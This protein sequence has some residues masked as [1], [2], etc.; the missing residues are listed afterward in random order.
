MFGEKYRWKTFEF[1]VFVN[2]LNDAH[3]LGTS[4]SYS[5]RILIPAVT[6]IVIL[7]ILFLPMIP[8][9]EA[10][11]AVESY[12]REAL[13]ETDNEYLQSKDLFNTYYEYRVWVYN[14]D[15]F[16]GGTFNVTFYLYVGNEL[17]RA[18]SVSHELNHAISF[19]NGLVQPTYSVFQT[20]FD[21]V[22]STQYVTG[23]FIVSPPHGM[24]ERTVSKTRIIYRSVISFFQ[25]P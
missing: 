22:P 15:T 8:T 14:N 21:T 4:H 23:S 6:I 10:Y 1:D 16:V 20:F 18:Q 13:Y 11:S 2:S 7:L 25:P 9:P 3:T 19:G 12:E 17:F 5:K 24:A